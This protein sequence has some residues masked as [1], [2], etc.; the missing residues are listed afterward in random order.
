MPVVE[1]HH[2]GRCS[3]GPPDFDDFAMAIALSHNVSMHEEPVS[4]IRH[5]GPIIEWQ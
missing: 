1:S 5:H 3:L 2:V 4:D